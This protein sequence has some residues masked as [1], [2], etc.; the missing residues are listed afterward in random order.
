MYLAIFLCELNKMLF[1]VILSQCLAD[2]KDFP[3]LVFLLHY[4]Y[5]LFNSHKNIARYIPL[6]SL[7][8]LTF[9]DLPKLGTSKFQSSH[10]EPDFCGSNP[11]ATILFPSVN[12]SLECKNQTQSLLQ[13]NVGQETWVRSLGWQ[14]PLEKGMATHSSILV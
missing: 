11:M 6:F 14:D 8:K 3:K 4:Y 1:I 12:F 13:Y 9:Y 5:F 2:R 7:R 10:A